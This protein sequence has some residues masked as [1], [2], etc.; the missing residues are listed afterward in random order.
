MSLL[1][2]ARRA[3]V[4]VVLAASPALAGRFT[5]DD[6]P[7]EWSGFVGVETRAFFA[8]PQFSAQSDDAVDVSVVAAPEWYYS[9]GDGA[10]SVVA[11]PFARGDSVDDERTHVDL[12]EL[13][14]L[15][16]ADGW[17]LRVGIGKVFW[18]VTESIHLV[19]I[20][21]QD[22][23]VEDVDGEDK[24]GQP[25]L[26]LTLLPDIGT[27]HAFVLPGFRERTYPGARGRLRPGIVID[28]DDVEYDAAW[29]QGNID[30]A[31]R[32]AMT[33]GQWDVGLS[34]FYG[35][36][37][38]PR[39]AVRV[40]GDDPVEATDVPDRLRLAPIYDLVNQTGLDVQYTGDNVLLKLEAVGRAGQGDYR[41]QAAA[42]FEYTFY[43]VF[44]GDADV[45]AVGEFLYDS[46]RTPAVPGIDQLPPGGVPPAAIE[47]D[48]RLALEAPPS[49][50]ENDVFAGFR[51]T[52]NDVQSTALL[53]GAI[54]DV[55]DGSRFWTVEASRRLG[56]R[57]TLSVDVRLFDG[58]ASDSFFASI[59]QDDFI[60]IQLAR[61]F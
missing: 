47:N 14:Y 32:W 55:K 17:E 28:E 61:Y 43:A 6:L 39:F 16:V 53:A 19:D 3:L 42:G 4:A 36:G 54:V 1:R 38:D 33:L 56:D 44:G 51:L 60:Q 58:F 8:K 18:G 48:P 5:V 2:V 57:Y 34:H 45:G 22:D 46:F 24:L 27:L 12:R 49:P 40:L 26:H 31:A 13:N 25:M 7:G 59:E 30:F 50:F 35:T 15:H 11:V 52:L 10:H 21:N 23:A 41:A 9:W 29:G 37:R 20:I